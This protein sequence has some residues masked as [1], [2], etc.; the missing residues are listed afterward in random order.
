MTMNVSHLCPHRQQPDE[1]AESNLSP[2]QGGKTMKW[3]LKPDGG[4]W[5]DTQT[6]V[7][8]DGVELAQVR[9]RR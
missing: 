5:P 8:E 1:Q 9:K 4:G 6:R 7:S 2:R 3:G